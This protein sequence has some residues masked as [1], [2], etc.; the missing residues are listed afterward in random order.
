MFYVNSDFVSGPSHYTYA[1]PFMS[2]FTFS[3]SI[4]RFFFA[5]FLLHFSILHFFILLFSSLL[6]PTSSIHVF[7]SL[8]SP[9]TFPV[10]FC[11]L[12]LLFPLFLS[13][14]VRTQNT[15]NTQIKPSLIASYITTKLS[16][17]RLLSSPPLFMFS[18]LCFL[19]TRFQSPCVSHYVSP[20]MCVCLAHS[21]SASVL[22]VSF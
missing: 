22:C 12:L 10:F 6:L 9:N 21:V 7:F 8:F 17:S 16:S 1:F 4:F 2:F 15:N 11:F 18:F 14:H 20:S 13:K 19:Q 5:S 3:S